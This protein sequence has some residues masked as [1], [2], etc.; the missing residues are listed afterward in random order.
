[1]G[2]RMEDVPDN[3][4]KKIKLYATKNGMGVADAR[5]KILDNALDGDGNVNMNFANKMKEGSPY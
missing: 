4:H 1:M 2:T 3:I 5:N